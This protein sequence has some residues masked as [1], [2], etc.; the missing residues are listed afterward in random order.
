MRLKMYRELAEWWQL[1]TPHEDYRDEAQVYIE[2][3]EKH[4]NI[5]MR[6]ILEL[7]S[8]GGNNSHYLREK[9]TMTLVDLS[10]PMLE[11]SCQIN[12][13]CEHLVGD[14][15]TLD[16][17]REFDG[18]L[19]A[20]AVMYMT[21]ETDLRSALATAW[22]HLRPGGV[23]VVA[24]DVMFETFRPYT[25]HSGRDG[26]N[27]AFRYLEWAWDPD[28]NDTEYF[29]EFC[30]LMRDEHN[31]VRSEYE[32][33]T[34]GLFKYETWLRLFTD[35]GFDVESTRYVDKES[36]KVESEIFVAVKDNRAIAN[37]E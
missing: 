29:V 9:F 1:L 14:M 16:L 17:G 4:S 37:E 10:E 20:D 30:Y 11:M 27:R 12:P 25:T 26:A 33:H 8:G 36:G 7:G 5:I 13:D 3:F 31:Q 35:V 28:P 23:V 34:F 21:T 32:R 22:K 19:I 15:R 24:P 2:L 18:V 6:N